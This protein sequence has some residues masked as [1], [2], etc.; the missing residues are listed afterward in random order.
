MNSMMK[1]MLIITIVNFLIGCDANPQLTKKIRKTASLNKPSD[2][3]MP[4]SVN[5]LLKSENSDTIR[6]PKIAFCAVETEL[7]NENPFSLVTLIY[8]GSKQEADGV[9]ITIGEYSKEYPLSEWGAGRPDIISYGADVKIDPAKM[10]KLSKYDNATIALTKEGKKISK[11][12]ELKA[13]KHQWE[14]RETKQLVYPWPGEKYSMMSKKVPF[15]K[16][17]RKW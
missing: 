5:K 8:V 7:N 2:G 4:E 14:D 12:V 11:D 15:N 13:T 10:P 17:D 3:Y 1:Y 16:P 9:I 6:H